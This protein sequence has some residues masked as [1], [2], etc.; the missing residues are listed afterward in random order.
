[1]K[2]R[3]RHD[4]LRLGPSAEIDRGKLAGCM[5]GPNDFADALGDAP[6]AQCRM[7]VLSTGTGPEARLKPK[8]AKCYA[9]QFARAIQNLHVA[10]T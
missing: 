3:I 1:M 6:K 9:P 8:T 5:R 10:L 4:F 7:N 2:R